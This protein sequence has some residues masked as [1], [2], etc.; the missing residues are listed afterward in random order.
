MRIA[1]D[2]AQIQRALGDAILDGF[3]VAD[4]KR[5]HHGREARLEL[6][7]ELR[8]QVLADRHARADEQR[9]ARLAAHLLQ[10][11]V[12]LR[13]QPEDALGV[14][15]RDLARGR[16]RDASLRAVEQPRVEVLLELLIWNVTAGCVM[17]SASAALVNER[18]FATAWN[19]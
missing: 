11:R 15:E 5:R 4:E 7:D 18:C 19:T 12:E 13:G 3:G 8:Q 1:L 9:P 2:E 17:N 16:E 6:A 10:S 14:L